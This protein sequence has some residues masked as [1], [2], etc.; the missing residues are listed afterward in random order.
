MSASK[1]QRVRPAA[2]WRQ[3]MFQDRPRGGGNRDIF[4][5]RNIF[6]LQK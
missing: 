4:C 2:G 1:R 5:F 3:I 6:I